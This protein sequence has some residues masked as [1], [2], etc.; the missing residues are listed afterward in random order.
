[1]L[2]PMGV[3]QEECHAL[4]ECGWKVMLLPLGVFQKE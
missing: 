4:H 2:L 3:F 1:M